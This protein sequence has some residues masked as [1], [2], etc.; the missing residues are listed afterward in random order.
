ME[1][2]TQEKLDHFRK[3]WQKRAKEDRTRRQ[4]RRTEGLNLAREVAQLLVERYDAVEVCLIGSL[5]KKRAVHE[6]SDIDLVVRGLSG[7][8]YFSAL[9]DGY[10]LLSGTF[11]LDLIPLEDAGSVIKKSLEEEAELLAEK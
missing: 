6:K 7:D 1:S 10:R 5:A 2:L 4:E 3:G 9:A 11:N 8:R